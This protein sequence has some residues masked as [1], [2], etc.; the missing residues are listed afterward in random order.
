MSPT[1]S[2]MQELERD[3][4]ETER[5]RIIR[6]LLEDCTCQYDRGELVEMCGIHNLVEIIKEHSE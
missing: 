1:E 2:W 5:N 3:I 4:A 6:I